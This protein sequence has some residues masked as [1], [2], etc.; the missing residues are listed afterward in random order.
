M[1]WARASE[2]ERSVACPASTHLA[3]LEGP[4]NAAAEWGTLLHD[5]KETGE[6]AKGLRKD[7]IARREAALEEAGYTRDSL[8][9][10]GGGHEVSFALHTAN[11][12]CLSHE[13]A[14]KEEREQWKKSFNEDWITGTA[15][16]WLPEMAPGISWVDDLKTGRREY[17]PSPENSWQLRFYAICATMLSKADTVLVSFLSW[18]RTPATSTPLRIW[19]SLERG[20]LL[21]L[22]LPLLEYARQNSRASL[23]GFPDTRP[24]GHCRFCKSQEACPADITDFVL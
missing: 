21:D 24:G 1:P 12:L 11:R 8:W 18:P 13:A 15:D 10:A 7:V 16:W 23:V 6:W 3:R 4:R 22:Y 20:E 17:L 5:W 14:T 19:G 2:L 9:P